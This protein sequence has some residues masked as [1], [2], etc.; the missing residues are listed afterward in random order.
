MSE[1]ACMNRRPRTIAR[2]VKRRKDRSRR[3]LKAVLIYETFAAGERARGFFEKLACSSG[4]TLEEQTW[5]FDGLRI[6]EARNAAASAA[7]KA[8]IVAVCASARLELPGTIRAWLDM[9]VWLLDGEEPA[10]M[11]LFDSPTAPQI[12]SVR[13][14]LS[15]LAR[16]AELEFFVAYREITSS[17]AVRLIGDD[18]WPKAA[19]QA[20]L[21]WLKKK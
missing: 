9:W 2:S 17:P 11:A 19:E 10:F 7:R 3:L 8:D 13:D 14:Y 1:S 4:R 5:S 12:A 18:L 6:R 16:R 21:L 15:C 20:V